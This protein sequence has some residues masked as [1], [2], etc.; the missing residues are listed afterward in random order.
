MSH[1]LTWLTDNVRNAAQTC[2]AIGASVYV[3]T[4]WDAASPGILLQ[5][6]DAA[7]LPEMVDVASAEA[8]ATH[9]LPCLHDDVSHAA[10]PFLASAAAGG[11]LIPI[12]MLA[13]HWRG[14]SAPALPDTTPGRR[15]ADRHNAPPIVGW[16][17]LRFPSESPALATGDWHTL[18]ALG[19]ALASTYV[20]FYG[21]LTDP[22]TGLP[23]RAELTATIRAEL[24]HLES[25]GLPFAL[26]LV[27]LE[28]LDAINQRLGRR[29]GD[30]VLREFLDVLQ[31]A[32]RASDVVMRYGGAVFAL[33]LRGV[34]DSGALIV[35]EKVRRRV[36][37]ARVANGTLSCAVGVVSCDA[38]DGRTL[39]P[40][41]LLRRADQAL[42]RACEI[43]GSQVV[44]WR[45][46]GEVA[47]HKGLDPL[48]GVFT[49]QVEKDYRNM[50][51]LWDVLQALSTSAGADLAA[52][53]VERIFSLFS[54]TRTALFLPD[55]EGTL[56][57]ACGRIESGADV[58]ALTAADLTDAEW[59][60]NRQAFAHHEQHVFAARGADAPAFAVP[61][62]VDTK[63]IG[64][65]YL[66]SDDGSLK[67]DSSDFPILSA[68]AT[69]L[70]LA[71]DRE[72][73]ASQQRLR[74]QREQALLKSEVHRLRSTMQQNY[75]VF[76]SPQSAHLFE[77]ARR[78]A[79]TEATGTRHG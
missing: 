5:V 33:P 15:L 62:F 66:R 26:V 57:L 52:A 43:G 50:R 22:V 6:G 17:A 61:L 69:H 24:E 63:P 44:L 34:A 46:D 48:L 21:I 32:V 47:R 18:V 78:V 8:F 37:E 60:L 58:R 68:V 67:M 79:A 7:P 36:A 71:L 72:R 73:L 25:S 3:P 41:E 19:S 53:A 39:E 42:S 40:I 13:A 51:L 14:A 70:A 30:V 59:Q 35:G 64:T 29:G 10:R 12:P 11:C 2:G 31:G 38:V 76:R 75:F 20:S 4:S 54:A 55:G 45:A 28:G 27:K 9:A 16:L 56:R 23:G 1:L 65:L 49:G 74:E 77:T